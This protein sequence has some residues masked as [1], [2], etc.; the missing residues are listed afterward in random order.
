MT[1]GPDR[2]FTVG[3]VRLLPCAV[4]AVQRDVAQEDSNKTTKALNGPAFVGI[5]SGRFHLLDKQGRLVYLDDE[6]AV[7]GNRR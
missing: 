6:M 5:P 7:A 4:R 2:S 3:N 1:Q